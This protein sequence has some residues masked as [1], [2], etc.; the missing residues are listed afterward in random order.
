MEFHKKKW[1][2][3]VCVCDKYSN[4]SKTSKTTFVDICANSLDGPSILDFYFLSPP[5]LN[6]HL[7]CFNSNV[8]NAQSQWNTLVR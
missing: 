3:V 7:F 5:K 6:K 8:D 2:L 4:F 1:Y